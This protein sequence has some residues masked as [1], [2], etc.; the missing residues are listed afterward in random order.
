MMMEGDNDDAEP[1]QSLPESTDDRQRMLAS[2]SRQLEWMRK[3]N[4]RLFLQ[5][6]SA[7]PIS[8]D[9]DSLADND[10]FWIEDASKESVQVDP[11]VKCTALMSRIHGRKQH[12]TVSSG[13]VHSKSAP[14]NKV[15]TKMSKVE[16]DDDDD[17]YVSAEED[18]D[19]E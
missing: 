8:A 18:S 3:Q 11:L 5:D 6:K 17:D 12:S 13:E 4:T 14:V 16:L 10:A 9:L 15:E 19:L 1:S 7:D 2:A